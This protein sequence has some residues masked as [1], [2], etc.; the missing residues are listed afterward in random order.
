MKFT[1]TIKLT[2]QMAG[3]HKIFSS[4]SLNID[5]NIKF[6]ILLQSFSGIGT[7][8]RILQHADF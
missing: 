1:R 4:D 6:S 2:K 3:N 8:R 5:C 7:Y